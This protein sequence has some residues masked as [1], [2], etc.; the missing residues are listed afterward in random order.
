MAG[1]PL[2]KLA[3]SDLEQSELERLVRRRKSAQA[4][5][6]RA[7]IILRC[8]DGLTN[9]E[10][11]EELGISF[12][13]VGKWRERFREDRVRG[14]TDAPRSGPPRKVGDDR[15][16]EI[17]A[18]TLTSRPKSATHWSTREMAAETGLSQATISRMWRTFGL[19]P[20]RSESF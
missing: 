13:T 2:R 8:A 15:V 3:L 11:A 10:V 19:Q 14:L 16:E 7:K 4:L 6:L 12:V 17:I 1:R 20:Y 5:A 9:T 18:K